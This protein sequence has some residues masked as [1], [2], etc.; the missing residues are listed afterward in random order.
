MF[1][2][3]GFAPDLYLAGF[4]DDIVAFA[5]DGQGGVAGCGF[6]F[7]RVAFLGDDAGFAFGYLVSYLSTWT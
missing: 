7:D 6:L 4:L 5:F 1:L 2:A 3:I